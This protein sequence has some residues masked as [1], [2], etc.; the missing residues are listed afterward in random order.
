MAVIAVLL[1]GWQVYLNAVINSM[2]LNPGCVSAQSW[3][4][5][6][7]E[8]VAG[9]GVRPDPAP[10]SRCN[11]GGHGAPVGGSL[12]LGK[13]LN[14]LCFEMMSRDLVRDVRLLPVM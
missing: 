7:M 5:P 6:R 12:L 8:V 10:G 1:F 13:V 3:G 9:D 2:V 14:T 4:A 11:G